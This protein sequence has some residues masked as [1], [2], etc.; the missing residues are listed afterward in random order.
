MYEGLKKLFFSL[1][2]WKY[3]CVQLRIR[4]CGIEFSNVQSMQGIVW[5]PCIDSPYIFQHAHPLNRSCASWN[6]HGEDLKGRL[7]VPF[8]GPLHILKAEIGKL[9]LESYV[10]S[11]EQEHVPGVDLMP[12]CS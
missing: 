12:I 10:F 9:R 8:R 3:T 7:R 1:E 6:V 2:I 11:L 5:H 4:E